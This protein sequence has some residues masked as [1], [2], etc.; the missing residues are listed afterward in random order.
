MFKSIKLLKVVLS[1][2]FT[3]SV[4]QSVIPQTKKERGEAP[5]SWSLIK[6]LLVL[7][8]E[9]AFSKLENSRIC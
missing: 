6:R 2:C 5:S 3:S 1:N 7:G 9:F 8:L 4:F